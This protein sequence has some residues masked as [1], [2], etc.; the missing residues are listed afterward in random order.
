M[1]SIV[2]TCFRVLHQAASKS[3]LLQRLACQTLLDMV[4]EIFGRLP[5]LPASEEEGELGEAEATQGTMDSTPFSPRVEAREGG[6]E[7]GG[8]EGVQEGSLELGGTAV[9]EG[10][11]GDGQDGGSAG[12]D[13]GVELGAG[14]KGGRGE[15]VLDESLSFSPAS[16]LPSAP[17]K[18][19]PPAKPAE[20]PRGP[21]DTSREAEEGDREEDGERGQAGSSSNGASMG[22]LGRPHGVACA[23]EV[24]HFLCSLLGLEDH[25][26]ALFASGMLA[27]DDVSL[28]AL[29][30]IS[31]ALELAGPAVVLHPR[32]LSLVQDELFRSLLQLGLSPNLL[33]LSQVLA[34]VQTLFHSARAHLKLQLEAFY[35]CV[36]ARLVGTAGKFTATSFAQQEAALEALLD[37]CRLPEFAVETYANFDADLTCANCLEELS[38]LLS[39]AAFPVNTPLSSLH[40]LAMQ[41]LLAVRSIKR[42]LLIGVEHFN[43]D[44]KKGLQ[45]LQASALLPSQPDARAV[46]CFLRFTP[47]L[48]KTL[49]GDLLGGHEEFHVRVLGEFAKL[50]DFEGMALDAAL[51]T[52]LEG[53]RLPGEAQKISR[54]LEAFAERYY[55]QAPAAYGFANHDV[56]YVL[57]YSVIMLNTDLYNG[58]V[59]RKM[60]EEEFIRNNRKINDGKDLPRELLSELYHAIA[61]NE[62]KMS[63]DVSLSSSS[64]SAFPE[65]N[66]SRWLG[67]IRRSPTAVP[68]ILASSADP[69]PSSA[70]DA[71]AVAPAAVVAGPAIAAISVVFDHTEDDESLLRCCTDGFSAAADVAAFHGFSG[72]LDDLVVSLC[73]CTTLRLNPSGSLPSGADLVD[74]AAAVAFGEDTK[75]RLAAVTVFGLA[76]RHGGVVRGG[77]RNLLDCVVRLHKLGLLP[78]RVIIE[79]ANAGPPPGP[80]VE[81]AVFGLLRLCRKLLPAADETLADELLR[82][83]QHVLRLDARLADALCERITRGVLGIVREGRQSGALRRVKSPPGWRTLA[84]LLAITARHPDAAA[85]GFEALSWLMAPIPPG[86]AAPGASPAALASDFSAGAVEDYGEVCTDGPPCVSPCNFIPFLDAARDFAEARVGG[87]E[88]SKRALDL[89]G[90]LIDCLLEW[91]VAGEMEQAAEADRQATAS[92]AMAGAAGGGRIDGDSLSSDVSSVNPGAFSPQQQP[93]LSAALS[94]PQLSPIPSSSSPAGGG[95]SGAGAS[96]GAGRFSGQDLADLWLRL[97]HALRRVCSDQR[98]DVRNHALVWLQR[99]LLAADPL[100]MPNTMWAPCFDQVVFVLLDD[101]LEVHLREKPKEY[102]GMDASLLRAIKTLSKGVLQVTDASDMESLWSATWRAVHAM[103]PH[104]KPESL[105]PPAP[106]AVAPMAAGP[107][108]AGTPGMEGQLTGASVAG[109]ALTS[110]VL[111]AT[112]CT[113]A[114]PEADGAVAIESLA[115]ALCASNRTQPTA[116]TAAEA[117]SNPETA[118]AATTDATAGGA[119]SSTSGTHG[120]ILPPWNFDGVHFTDGGPLTVQYLLLLDALNFCFWPGNMTPQSTT[121]IW[122]EGLRALLGPKPFPLEQQRVQAARQVGR[123]LLR[124]FSGSA[125]E[126]VE[127]AGG[128]AERLVRLLTIHFPYFQDHAIYRGRQVA[129]FKR[130]QIFVADVWGA[131]NGRGLGHFSDIHRLTMFADYVV[132]AVLRSRGV[133]RYAAGLAAAVDGRE[134]ILPGSEEEVEIRACCIVVTE[135]LREQLERTVGKPVRSY[136]CWRLCTFFGG[137]LHWIHGTAFMALHSWHCIHGTAFMALHSWHCIHGTAFMA[138]H[139]WHCI[140][141]TAFMA[142]H[143]WHCIH[144]TAFMA[145]HSWHC[146]HGTAFMALHSWHCI[147]GTAFMAL[148]SW[149]CIHGTAFMALHSWHC[150]HGTAFMALHSWHCIHGTAFVALH[151]WHCIHGTAFMALHSWHC[152]HGTAFMALHSWHCIHGTAFMALHSWHCIHGTAFMA[153]HSW[154]CIHGTAFMA[155][156][157]W[158][159]IHGTAFMALHS[160]HCIHGTVMFQSHKAIGSASRYVLHVCLTDFEH[161]ARLAAML[162]PQ[163]LRGTRRGSATSGLSVRE[164]PAMRRCSFFDSAMRLNLLL[165]HASPFHLVFACPSLSRPIFA[166]HLCTSPMHPAYR[167]QDSAPSFDPRLTLVPPSQ[168]QNNATQPPSF[169]STRLERCPTHQACTAEGNVC[170]ASTAVEIRQHAIRAIQRN[171]APLSAHASFSHS[172]QLIDHPHQLT[173]RLVPCPRRLLYSKHSLVRSISY[174]SVFLLV[175]NSG[176][177]GKDPLITTARNNMATALLSHT[178]SV[179]VT[180]ACAKSTANPRQRLQSQFAGSSLRLPARLP[181]LRARKPAGISAVIEI[182]QEDI[183]TTPREPPKTILEKL[184]EMDDVGVPHKVWLS[185]VVTVKKRPYFFNREWLPKD[186]GYAVFLGAIHLLA[187]AAPFTFSWEAFE[188]FVAMYVITGMFGI[189]LSFHRHLTHHSFILPKWL[190]YTFA[191]CGVLACQGPPFEWVSAHRVHHRWCDKPEDVHTP[192]EGFWYSHAGWLLDNEALEARLEGKNNIYD[193]TKDPFYQFIDKTYVWHIV[194]SV[195]AL[196]ALGGFPFVVWGW[197]LRLVWVYHITWFVNSASHVWGDQPWNTGDLSRNNWWV[198]ILAFG[199]GWHNNHHAFEYSARHGLE[200]WQIDMTW[201]TLKLLEAVGL[202]SNLRYPREKHM[203]KLAYPDSPLAK[204]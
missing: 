107:V 69:E 174:H 32:L 140:H 136:Q 108:G 165:P 5:E 156:H 76:N 183:L 111:I 137:A 157:S 168:Q 187:L 42:R 119:G 41:G 13:P 149:H 181:Q 96:G 30:L 8:E 60:T 194:A 28:L 2:N 201:Y 117:A 89:L 22:A 202:A 147:H 110:A 72:A 154:H 51:R 88:R 169:P 124:R 129:L 58:Q 36:I 85:P 158:H 17:P 171:P 175:R 127:E 47:G 102:R 105:V 180:V 3:H 167:Q 49:V 20:Q 56:A 19:P 135:R 67:L 155:L 11:G 53:F 104:L 204:S 113:A 39:R 142:L 34:I 126:M 98:E 145:L 31:A 132:P 91:R 133:L 116:S 68:Y 43:R 146:I 203:K 120:L 52:F 193:L 84:A 159:C 4:R 46:A 177:F 143:S 10:G 192:Y 188:C 160:W 6:V 148:H 33:V 78:A 141:G 65:M 139:S 45:F 83:L 93:P 79:S 100:H 173:S 90:C 74:N 118:A 150:I 197:A 73:R 21:Q 64:A 152:I 112:A 27:D 131:F 9:E 62:I 44:S 12:L 114:L 122:L 176:Y 166:H 59:R 29:S 190:E 99:C 144:G 80:L 63:S 94:P 1:C 87:S 48:N 196:Y 128:S 71:A 172:L 182:E 66:L 151:S 115:D 178:A 186:I 164:G 195:A 55:A 40:V 153:L 70:D 161:R 179:P 18:P 77:W 15:V 130:A 14:E 75:A 121:S 191:Y 24:F 7:G 109:G 37:F 25:Q 163:A 101:L 16:I 54:V 106:I 38:G 50:F 61:R 184:E 82:S 189:T 92:A 86:A 185:D 170:G 200:W 26:S 95:V 97:L 199:E 125:A 138:L 35:T 81:R 198:G 123:V 134:E 103:L 23:V 162:Y 57:S